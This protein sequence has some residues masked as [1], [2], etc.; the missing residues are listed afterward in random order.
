MG[1]SQAKQQVRNDMAF[2][3]RQKWQVEDIKV[4]Q[5]VGTSDHCP[6]LL[7][8]RKRNGE[9]EAQTRLARDRDVVVR[10][11]D[12]GIGRKGTIMKNTK[13]GREQVF[14]SF[15][16]PLITMTVENEKEKVFIDSGAPFSIYNPPRKD[17]QK[18]RISNLM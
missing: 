11:L 10:T 8:L 9:R 18:D 3:G 7:Q 14:D 13:T 12:T 4:F 1:A 6:L 5:G 2:D 15:R 16:C 17:P